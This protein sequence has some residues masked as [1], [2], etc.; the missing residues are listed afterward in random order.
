MT[1]LISVEDAQELIQ[2]HI[3]NWGTENVDLI[4]TTGRIIAQ[5]VY[6]DRDFPPYHRVTM[7]GFAFR[8]D[9]RLE[10]YSIQDVQLAGE[11]P[12]K[13][14]PG[15][16]I[17]IMTGAVI[18]NGA[19]TVIPYEK[20]EVNAEKKLVYFKEVPNKSQNVHFAG[21]D[22]S[23]GDLLLKSGSKIQAPQ[24]AM[25]STC[26]L[27]AVK[28]Y[29]CPSVGLI[30]TGDEL[31]GIESTPEVHQIRSSNIWMLSAQLTAMGLKHSHTHIPDEP[32][33]METQIRKL[34]KTHQVLIL[35]GGVSK[36]KADLVLPTLKNIGFRKVFH[37]VAQRPGKP[38]LFAKMDKKVV[39][40]LPGNPMAALVGF[41]RYVKPSLLLNL[42]MEWIE[43]GESF[44]FPKP[45]TY[46]LQVRLESNNGSTLAIPIKGNGSGDMVNA[47]SSSGF[48]ELSATQNTF[49]SGE[50]YPFFR[51]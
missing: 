27:S 34:L 39:F 46:F 33:I 18:P 41:F 22:A 20:T 38:L 44:D 45:L 42:D 36:G 51:Y 31:V 7:D 37:G 19:D 1:T 25:L 6:A 28:C 47:L 48:L 17:E 29:K 35:S 32:E 14:L 11:K 2:Q 4:N 50:K 3:P 9:D 24:Q 15:N 8:A 12:K 40:G 10:A 49:Q 43:L 13:L 23:R 30:S 16:V 21:S 5:N 26:G